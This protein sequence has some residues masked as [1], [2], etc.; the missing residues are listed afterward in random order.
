MPHNPMDLPPDDPMSVRRFAVSG[1]GFHFAGVWLG[2]GDV[3]TSTFLGRAWEILLERGVLLEVDYD[4]ARL[5][6]K[7]FGDP[8]PW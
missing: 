3:V 2:P 7:G 1:S 6:Q 5:D 4:L 8:Y